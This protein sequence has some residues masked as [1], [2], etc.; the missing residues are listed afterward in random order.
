LP[1]KRPTDSR[2]LVMQLIVTINI[3]LQAIFN[4]IQPGGKLDATAKDN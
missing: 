2:M 4:A 3:H 1:M